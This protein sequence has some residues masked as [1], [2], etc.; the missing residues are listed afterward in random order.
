[1][2]QTSQSQASQSIVSAGLNQKATGIVV[3]NLSAK[4]IAGAQGV[5]PAD[6]NTDFV[7]LFLVIFDETGSMDGNQSAVHQSFDE[8]VS[9]LKGS[10]EADSIFMS[11]WTFNS[12][13]TNLVHSY[14]PLDLVTSLSGYNPSAATNLFDAVL[15]GIT[16]LLLY[17]TELVKYGTRLQ[18]VVVI[19]TDG[20]DND[21]TNPV[22]AVKTLIDDLLTK[23]KY[24][25]SLVAFG[26]GFAHQTAMKMGIP[27]ANVLEVGKTASEIRHAVGTVSKSVIRTSQ[28]KIGSTSQSG[29]FNP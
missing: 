20:E 5:N 11:A 25:F 14:L 19:F 1:M 27:A 4:T 8:M 12:R 18:T 9:A 17:E 16:S 3:K 23:E 28:T 6:L 22:S 7:T 2:S 13:R 26:R 10:K 24:I 15:D 21:S 29:F